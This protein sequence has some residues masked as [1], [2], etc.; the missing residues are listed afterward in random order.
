MY[1]KQT[2]TFLDSYQASSNT[3]RGNFKRGTSFNSVDKIGPFVDLSSDSK[4]TGARF[5]K[6][7]DSVFWQDIGPHINPSQ[8]SYKA[9]VFFE[10][11]ADI[12]LFLSKNQ[13]SPSL[14]GVALLK[15][16]LLFFHC[17]IFEELISAIVVVPC[18]ADSVLFPIIC[19]YPCL[20]VSEKESYCAIPNNPHYQ[21]IWA[22]TTSCLR[23]WCHQYMISQTSFKFV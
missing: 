12:I 11:A 13:R 3:R 14:D 17:S 21:N 1:W 15:L 6:S 16:C 2:I 9:L 19:W 7:N 4:V 23:Y 8:V 22:K 5:R 18:H 20:P 10:A